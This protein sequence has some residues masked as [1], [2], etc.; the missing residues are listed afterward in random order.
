MA[1]ADPFI[2][3]LAA[4]TLYAIRPSTGEQTLEVIAGATERLASRAPYVAIAVDVG[5]R[6]QSGDQV[7]AAI[8]KAAFVAA[9]ARAGF[10]LG[11]EIGFWVGE[12]IAPE[13]GGGPGALIGGV[14]LSVVAAIYG[15][16]A[17]DSVSEA[18]GNFLGGDTTPSNTPNPVPG[19]NPALDPGAASG[20]ATP[21]S[22]APAPTPSPTPG[23]L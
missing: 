21:P 1:D 6:V 18:L 8:A 4:K 20:P 17:V 23:P 14:V 3:R 15:E 7:T 16:K 10:V 22:M 5:I 9:N 12:A 2:S 19:P 11:A 13:G